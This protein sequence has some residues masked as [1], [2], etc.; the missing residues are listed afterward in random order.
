MIQNHEQDKSNLIPPDDGYR[1]LHSYQTAQ[2]VY[3]A[4]VVFCNLF[5]D[6][7]SRTHDKIV[8]AA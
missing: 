1:N 4:T 2:S 5:V 6:K 8:Q 3:D 7:H